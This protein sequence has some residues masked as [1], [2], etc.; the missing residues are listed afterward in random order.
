MTPGG[1]NLDEVIITLRRVAVL[2][3]RLWSDSFDSDRNRMSMRLGDAS[4]SVYRALIAL[5]D[6]QK[7]YCRQI[8]SP[9]AP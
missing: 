4:H 5:E 1:E 3:D 8:P 2:I 7:Q 6:G 9:R